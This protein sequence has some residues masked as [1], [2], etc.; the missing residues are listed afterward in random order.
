MVVAFGSFDRVLS[1]TD[2]LVAVETA[3]DTFSPRVFDGHRCL[4]RQRPVCDLVQDFLTHMNLTPNSL[5]GVK[6]Q[7]EKLTH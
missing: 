1:D 3:L 6:Y 2:K 4:L 5:E 7:F